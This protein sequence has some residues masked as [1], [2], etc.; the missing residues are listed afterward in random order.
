MRFAMGVLYEDLGVQRTEEQFR[1]DA[2][3]G[4]GAH[5]GAHDGGIALAPGARALVEEVAGSGLPTALV[6]TTPRRLASVVLAHLAEDLGGD[7]FDVRSAATRCPPASPIPRLPAGDGRPRGGAGRLRGHRGL[8]VGVTSGPAPV[9]RCSACRPCSPLAAAPGLVP[10]RLT[11]RGR[12]G[13]AGGGARGAGRGRLRRLNQHD[14]DRCDE[15][16]GRRAV[17]LLHDHGVLGTPTISLDG[18][19]AAWTATCPA[20]RAATQPL[21]AGWSPVAGSGQYRGRPATDDLGMVGDGAG[22]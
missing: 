20:F 22:A 8:L 3:L 6:T 11:G 13:R 19:L 2:Q 17:L 4:R 1:A 10:A 12:P 16:Q 15:G 7:P 14:R 21:P 5:P 9:R 18:F